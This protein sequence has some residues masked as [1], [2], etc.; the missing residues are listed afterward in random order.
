MAGRAYNILQSHVQNRKQYNV[1]NDQISKMC[2]IMRGVTQGSIL[3]SLLFIIY[4]NNLP[5]FV[6]AHVTIY[7][8]DTTL[9]ASGASTEELKVEMENSLE[10]VGTWFNDNKLL[11]NREKNLA[12]YL[13]HRMTLDSWLS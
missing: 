7:A 4:I 8:D 10:V 9:T 5:E 11:L 1:V 2:S 6:K 13:H 12:D 3:G